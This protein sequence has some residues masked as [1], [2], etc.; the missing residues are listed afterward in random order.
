MDIT[1]FGY[2][3]EGACAVG[4]A[5]MLA[6]TIKPSRAEWFLKPIGRILNGPKPS[7][8]PRERK[9]SIAE[10]LEEAIKLEV[11][12]TDVRSVLKDVQE[13]ADSYNYFIQQYG[14]QI[15]ANSSVNIKVP[16]EVGIKDAFQV[17]SG[18]VPKGNSISRLHVR[19]N[20]DGV[21]L[22]ADYGP[23]KS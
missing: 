8:E 5:Y 16:T 17:L 9:Q 14:N 19:K 20:S 10:T 11:E 22:T 1:T 6:A 7:R 21:Y 12:N 15:G 18:K 4:A 2:I 13:I 3:V 23:L